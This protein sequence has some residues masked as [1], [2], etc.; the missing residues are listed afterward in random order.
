MGNTPSVNIA[1]SNGN[2]LQNIAVIDGLAGFIGTGL[3]AGNLNKVFSINSLADAISQGITLAAEPAAYKVI[4]EFYAE[5]GGNQQMYILLVADTVLMADMLDVN[6]ISMGNKLIAAGGGKI[7]CIGVFRNPAVGYV[8]GTDFFDTDVQAAVLAAKTFVQGLNSK[9]SFTRVLIQGRIA[10]EASITIFAPNT[11]TNGFAGVVLGDTVSGNGATVGTAVGR[12][13]K[14]ASHIKI[15]KVANGP[16]NASAIF[17]GTKALKDVT[18]LD[19]LHGKG[20][21]S[22]VTYPNKAGFYFGI[23]N[24]ASI[25]DYRL[26]VYGCT[27]DAAAKVAASVYIDELEGEVNTNPDGTI[28]ELDAKHLEDR[29]TQQVSVSLGDRISGFAALV[30]RTSNIITTSKTKIKLRVRPKGYNTFIDVDL[31]LTAG[32]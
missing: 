10:A 30:D 6:S 8:P 3:V 13:I 20:V 22:F 19:T 14:Y 27:V 31:G 5:L 16:L 17:I 24:M 4:S 2:L 12:K 9:L 32:N 21:I 26:L 28:T 15:G 18:N 1:F 23:D 7:S 11:A 25:D 29:I